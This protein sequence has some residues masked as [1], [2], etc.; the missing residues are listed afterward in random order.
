MQTRRT[1]FPASKELHKCSGCISR[2]LS[3]ILLSKSIQAFCVGASYVVASTPSCVELLLRAG[4]RGLLQNYAIPLMCTWM[5][6]CN[7][8]HA[9][10]VCVRGKF[11]HD[12]TWPRGWLQAS[13]RCWRLQVSQL[14]QPPAAEVWGAYDACMCGFEAAVMFAATMLIGTS[15]HTWYLLQR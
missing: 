4:L 8:T 10:C 12:S 5:H 14:P 6:V 7:D 13:P 9:A 11:V 2:G 3:T 1:G 15:W